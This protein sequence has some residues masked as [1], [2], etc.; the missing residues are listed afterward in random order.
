MSIGG[1][2]ASL[3][4]ESGEFVRIEIALS[5]DEANVP[6]WLNK[7]FATDTLEFTIRRYIEYVILAFRT[8]GK[9]RLLQLWSCFHC[10][11]F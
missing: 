5:S 1:I 4:A 11:S 10:Y 2:S 9:C 7:V 6:R 3:V 8:C